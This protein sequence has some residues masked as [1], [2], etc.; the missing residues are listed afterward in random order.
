MLRNIPQINK[1]GDKYEINH[2]YHS[3]NGARNTTILNHKSLGV[4]SS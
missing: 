4:N 2:D 3:V 1:Q